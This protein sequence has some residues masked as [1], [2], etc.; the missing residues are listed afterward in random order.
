MNNPYSFIFWALC[1]YSWLF[2]LFALLARKLR[3][4]SMHISNYRGFHGMQF[5]FWS[6]TRFI[7]FYCFYFSSFIFLWLLATSSS[8]LAWGKAEKRGAKGVMQP[9]Y[10]VIWK[11]KWVNSCKNIWPWVIKWLILKLSSGQ[12][13]LQ[14]EIGNA[15][16]ENTSILT[17]ASLSFYY[18]IQPVKGAVIK[19]QEVI[20]C[21]SLG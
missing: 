9:I 6:A 10:W 4:K 18:V 5:V 2:Q 14:K 15:R 21:M 1:C 20:C 17:M 19:L 7:L 16:E 11:I 3:V 12:S 8:L 13:I